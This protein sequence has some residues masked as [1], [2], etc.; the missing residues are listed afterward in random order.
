MTKDKSL[1][2]RIMEG[3]ARTGFHYDEASFGVKAA[4]QSTRVMF[5]SSILYSGMKGYMHSQGIDMPSLKNSFPE[6]FANKSAHC[7]GCEKFGE[8][9]GIDE[10]IANIGT[11]IIKT[12]FWKNRTYENYNWFLGYIGQAFTQIGVYYIGRGIGEL[13]K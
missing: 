5:W 9:Y 12:I 7:T 10:T 4:Y 11:Q 2:R 8:S 13:T 1:V 3:E 6:D